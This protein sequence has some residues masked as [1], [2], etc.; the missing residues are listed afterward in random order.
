M[1]NAAKG[2]IEKWND[3]E[4]KRNQSV[5]SLLI[6]NSLFIAGNNSFLHA[7]E[8]GFKAALTQNE[9]DAVQAA[10]QK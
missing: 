8:R 6:Y 5:L 9:L 4:I 10:F 1:L 7:I 3:L 2:L